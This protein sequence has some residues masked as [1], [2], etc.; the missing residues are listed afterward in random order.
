MQTCRILY[1]LLTQRAGRVFFSFFCSLF[2]FLSSTSGLRR[3]WRQFS[4]SAREVCQRRCAR[5]LDR[6]IAIFSRYLGGPR[7]VDFFAIFWRPLEPG[8]HKGIIA[9]HALRFRTRVARTYLAAR[10]LGLTRGCRF[11]VAAV[12]TFLL[13][14]TPAQSQ[15]DVRRRD[16]LNILGDQLGHAR[17]NKRI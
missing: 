8:T 1:E 11:G 14:D 17:F 3:G 16:Q 12:R 10:V 15:G 5:L 2:A 9:K 13:H 6:V 7:R 4:I